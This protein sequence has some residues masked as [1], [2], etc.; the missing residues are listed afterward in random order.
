MGCADTCASASIKTIINRLS[1]STDNK[2]KKNIMQ[3]AAK[4]TDTTHSRS[5]HEAGATGISAMLPMLDAAA[6]IQRM[7]E[8]ETSSATE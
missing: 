5:D 1:T 6:P 7:G 4:T 2:N 3:A 8:G